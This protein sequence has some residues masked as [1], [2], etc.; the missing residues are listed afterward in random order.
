MRHVQSPGLDDHE[1][2]HA[3]T[4]PATGLDALIALHDTTL[5]PAAGGCRFRT[6]A[7]HEAALTDVLRL[8]RGM[9]Y[10]NALAGLPLGG[11]KAVL[12]RPAGSFDRTALF[13]AFGRAVDSLGGRYVTAEDVGTTVADMR[14]VARATRYVGGLAAAHGRAGGDPSPKTALGVFLA[15]RAAWQH[16]TGSDDLTGVRVAVQG[17]GGVGGHLLTHLHAAGARLFVADVNPAK[18]ADAVEAFGAIAVPAEMILSVDVDI[19]A[20]CALGG[21]LDATTIPRLTARVVA[22][23]ANNQLAT[24]EDGERLAARGI[25]YAPDYVVNAGGIISVAGE[26]LATWSE[27]DVQRR[28]E[29]IPDTLR[30]VLE[31][32]QRTGAATS[33]VADRLA[34]E[35]IAAAARGAWKHAS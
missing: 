5:G 20:P 9:S 11:G 13:E 33:D 17:V 12:R 35:H 29:R 27:A 28:I 30:R 26:Y 23:G 1:A 19:L 7:S 25:V 16:A 10:K 24:R 6:Y 14:A 32:A 4:D 31:E 18:I 3:F 15:L 2:V 21:V 34:R 22:G 8:S